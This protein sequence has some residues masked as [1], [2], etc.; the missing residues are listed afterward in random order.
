MSTPFLHTHITMSKAVDA[1]EEMAPEFTKLVGKDALAK[2]PFHTGRLVR[3]LFCIS[4][5]IP[6]DRYNPRSIEHIVL[7]QYCGGWKKTLEGPVYSIARDVD[8]HINNLMYRSSSQDVVDAQRAFMTRYS[9]I[10]KE[11]EARARKLL[12]RQVR[13]MRKPFVVYGKYNHSHEFLSRTRHRVN[14]HNRWVTPHPLP[15]DLT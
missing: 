4:N 3:V 11:S 13:Y 12:P 1:I 5:Y 8:Y 15:E 14:S 9:A 10:M 7:S 2:E 6:P